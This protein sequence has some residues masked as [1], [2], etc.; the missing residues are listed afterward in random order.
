MH[1]FAPIPDGGPASRVEA[2]EY[3][4]RGRTRDEAVNVNPRLKPLCGEGCT[5]SC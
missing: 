5:V 3:A 4:N 2:P 1:H